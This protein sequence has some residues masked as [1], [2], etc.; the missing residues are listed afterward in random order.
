VRRRLLNLLTVLSL[1]LCLSALGAWWRSTRVSDRLDRNGGA[2]DWEV[3]SV[4]GRLFVGRVA[5]RRVGSTPAGEPVYDVLGTPAERAA[6]QW[7]YSVQSPGPNPP[8]DMWEPSVWK[9]VGL[10]RGP[11]SASG[12][13][14]W[15]LRLRWSSLALAASVLP[16]AYALRRARRTPAGHCR[17]CGYD[18]RATPD[19]CPECG[20]AVVGPT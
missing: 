2:A 20:A 7:R 15:W 4:R 19:R 13:S 3:F 6:P 14:G 1:L 10:E 11:F 16:A 8:P 17:R 12:V 18:L 5:F 9:V